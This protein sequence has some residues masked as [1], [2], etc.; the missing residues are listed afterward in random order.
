MF[1]EPVSGCMKPGRI[2]PFQPEGFAPFDGVEKI[3]GGAMT[4]AHE[5]KRDSLVGDIFRG[6]ETPLSSSE[7]FLKAKR[8]R[9]IFI[10]R[11]PEGEKSGAVHED[12]NGR[13]REC[14]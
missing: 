10:A 3:Q 11:V 5:Q 9:V 4:M 6:E 13:H 2:D 8:G 14:D 12:I 1:A 7:S